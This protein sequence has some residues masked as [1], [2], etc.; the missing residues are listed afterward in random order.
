MSHKI[1]V[2]LLMGSLIGVLSGCWL[3]ARMYSQDRARVD[4]ELPAGTPTEGRKL[5]RK[6]Y[7]LEIIKDV[8]QEKQKKTEAAAKP[9][10][11]QAQQPPQPSQPVDQNL[12]WSAIPSTAPTPSS[13]ASESS[14]PNVQLPTTYTIEKDDTLQSIAKK[15]YN[16]HGKWTKIYDANRDKIPDPNRIK[17]GTVIAI[18]QL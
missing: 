10:E 7:F 6:V 5:T 1:L 15:F 4:Q 3:H 17:A 2:G 16:S 12:P 8:P 13:P 18:P 9:Q 11:A 14:V